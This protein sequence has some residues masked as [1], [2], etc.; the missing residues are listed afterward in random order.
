M[1]ALAEFSSQAKIVGIFKE[2][3][4]LGILS[5]AM[6]YTKIR[7]V[8]NFYFSKNLQSLFVV[9]VASQANLEEFS[10]ATTDFD[11]SFHT[12]LVIFSENGFCQSHPQGNPFHLG[13][14]SKVLVECD[15]WIWEWY[16]LRHNST[17]VLEVARWTDQLGLIGTTESGYFERRYDYMGKALKIA[18]VIR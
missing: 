18:T 13:F 7:E 2:L 3:V 6:R 12:W 4:A 11:M 16:S 10:A 8:S 9:F 15:G 14:D 5:Q 17:E 1:S